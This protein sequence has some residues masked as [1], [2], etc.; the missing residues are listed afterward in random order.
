[1]ATDLLEPPGRR[2]GCWLTSPFLFSGIVVRR[3]GATMELGRSMMTPAAGERSEVRGHRQQ[4]GKSAALTVGVNLIR[5]PYTRAR[6][7]R[8][9]A[10]PGA[11]RWPPIPAATFGCTRD[12][13]PPPSP[14]PHL[15]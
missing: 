15:I 2:S 11:S 14:Q 3:F 6:G 4:I 1:M 7:G 9:R 12:R 5:C 10:E 8:G 13:G